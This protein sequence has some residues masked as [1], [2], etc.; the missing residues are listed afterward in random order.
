M[1]LNFFCSFL[2]DVDHTNTKGA[3][4][5]K[6]KLIA[7]SIPVLIETVIVKNKYINMYIEDVSLRS[8]TT[9]L[10]LHFLYNYVMLLCRIHF[11]CVRTCPIF[12]PWNTNKTQPFF[13]AEKRNSNSILYYTKIAMPENI[14]RTPVAVFKF[15]YRLR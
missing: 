4:K 1:S 11:L 7:L 3:E 10:E 8:L 6:P 15:T 5:I 2:S 12:P 14:Y 13:L 9:H